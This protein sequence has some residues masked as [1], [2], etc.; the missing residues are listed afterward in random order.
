MGQSGQPGGPGP[1]LRLCLSRPVPSTRTCRRRCEW[2]PWSCVSRP[3]RN[4]PTTTRYWRQCRPLMSLATPV[5][6]SSGPSP[7][8]QLQRPPGTRLEPSFLGSIRTV[9]EAR[10]GEGEGGCCLQVLIGCTHTAPGGFSGRPAHLPSSG[11]RLTRAPSPSLRPVENRGLPSTHSCVHPFR[12]EV[13]HHPC[14]RHS[15]RRWQHDPTNRHRPGM[16]SIRL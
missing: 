9:G 14:A 2:R 15:S 11:G 6:E 8:S 10:A 13:K 4:S 7:H 16:S 12:K 1:G 3:V 5:G